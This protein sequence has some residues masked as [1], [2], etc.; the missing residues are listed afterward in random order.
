MFASAPL[1][2]PFIPIPNAQS[3]NGITQPQNGSPLLTILP[4]VQDYPAPL[5]NMEWM[6]RSSLTTQTLPPRAFL[7]NDR[8]TLGNFLERWHVTPDRNPAT[9]F[10]PTN[11]SFV[12]RIILPKA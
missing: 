10:F 11:N 1:F 7:H 3:Q 4:T 9:K 12:S 5:A 8:S 6:A 2:M